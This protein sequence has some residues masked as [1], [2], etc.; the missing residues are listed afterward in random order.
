MRIREATVDFDTGAQSGEERRIRFLK[1]E[2]GVQKI[3]RASRALIS[4]TI[5]RLI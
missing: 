4:V 2:V 1:E 3:C 5:N